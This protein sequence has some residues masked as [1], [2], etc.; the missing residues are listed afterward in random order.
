[1][2]LLRRVYRALGPIAGGILLDTIDLATFGPL[3]LY[4][5]WIIGL[6]VGWWMASIYKF[7]FYGKVLF[8]TLAAVYLTLPM[9]E[10]IPVATAVSAIA[11][12]RDV[13]KD[14]A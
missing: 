1:M 4:A 9:T 3:G 14:Q 12:F 11:R 2:E 8:A 5:G 7:H 13:P 10:F 6:A